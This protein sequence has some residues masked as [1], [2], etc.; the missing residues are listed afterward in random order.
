[1]YT[2]FKQEKKLHLH[3]PL[4]KLTLFQKGVQYSGSMIF[5]A[6]LGINLVFKQ[7]VITLRVNCFCVGGPGDWTVTLMLIKL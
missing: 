4:S 5:K 6:A 3:I 1:M 7:V 2:I